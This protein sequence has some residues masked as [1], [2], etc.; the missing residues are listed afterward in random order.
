MGRHPINASAKSNRATK[1]PLLSRAEKAVPV[2]CALIAF[3]TLFN[4]YTFLFPMAASLITL[5]YNIVTL[6]MMVSF[7][8]L[9]F[10]VFLDYRNRNGLTPAL[11][12]P[13]AVVINIACV[14]WSNGSLDI[15]SRDYFLVQAAGT[16]DQY[17]YYFS[18]LNV[19]L[20]NMGA[21]LFIGRYTQHRETIVKAVVAVFIVFIVPILALVVTHPEALGLRQSSFSGSDE[22]F[23]GGLWNIGVIGFGSLSWLAMALFPK[24]NLNQRR[25]IA[26]SVPL[27]IAAGLAGLSRTL[28]L[29]AL[30]SLLVYLFVAKKDQ[31]WVGKSLIVLIALVLVMIFGTSLFQPLIERFSGSS[32]GHDI[33]FDL[34]VSYLSH[35]GDTWLVGAPEG[36][37]YLYYADVTLMGFH[38]MPHSSVINFLIRFGLLG[39]VSYLCLIKNAFFVFPRDI[40]KSL[41][42]CILAAATAYV[43]LSFINQTGYEEP[44]FYVMFGLFIAYMKLLKR[45]FKG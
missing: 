14:V 21:V 8:P 17:G 43:S 24:A 3:K 2:V 20:G 13:L 7:I 44:I 10:I 26:V 33:R 19:W 1:A 29:M 39:C 6:L 37:V 18:Q 32:G 31:K 16:N 4:Y 22:V 5:V 36:S 45:D 12:I 15:L 28:V 11:L 35:V 9:S 25:V 42:A 34:W 40:D 38:Y 27:F 30:L 23:G 41:K